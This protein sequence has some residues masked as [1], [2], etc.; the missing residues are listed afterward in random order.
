M[1][2]AGSSFENLVVEHFQNYIKKGVKFS[3]ISDIEKAYPNHIPKQVANI[4]EFAKDISTEELENYLKKYYNT[5]SY[6]RYKSLFRKLIALYD[7]KKYS[8][9]VK[10]GTIPFVQIS[11][12]KPSEK[13]IYLVLLLYKTY[14]IIIPNILKNTIGHNDEFGILIFEK[15]FMHFLY[16]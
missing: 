15:F 2:R 10:E 5:E 3:S 1:P 13:F 7:F 9:K 6:Q 8:Q 4:K 11:K 14:V 12:K 16:V